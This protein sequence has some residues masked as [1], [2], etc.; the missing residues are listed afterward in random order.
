MG[1]REERNQIGHSSNFNDLGAQRWNSVDG[2]G[3]A[4]DGRYGSE[5]YGRYGR[6][7]NDS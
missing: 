1:I 5:K 3:M 6:Y 2:N 4:T 7:D